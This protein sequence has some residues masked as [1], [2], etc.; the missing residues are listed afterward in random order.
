MTDTNCYSSKVFTMVMDTL[1]KSKKESIII[2]KKC[3]L[4]NKQAFISR[5]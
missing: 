4:S 5:R 2:L 1:K 3:E